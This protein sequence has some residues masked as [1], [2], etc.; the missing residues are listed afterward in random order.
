VTV[1]LP[2]SHREGTQDSILLHNARMLKMMC[3]PGAILF[4]NPSLMSNKRPLIL[5]LCHP[6]WIFYSATAFPFVNET[7]PI[8]S[9]QSE[10]T[11]M[12]QMQINKPNE[13]CTSQDL[14]SRGPLL[15]EKDPHP[16]R[17]ILFAALVSRDV[18]VCILL[19]RRRPSLQQM[20]LRSG[21][22]ALLQRFCLR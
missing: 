10:F 14:P 5:H 15:L 8:R 20:K 16:E 13:S 17:A 3:W 22:N 6:P 1:T 7:W 4:Q 9:D 2:L 11:Q 21:Y 19:K 18:Q 12:I